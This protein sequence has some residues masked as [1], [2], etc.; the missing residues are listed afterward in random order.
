MAPHE[1]SEERT[2]R[3][4]LTGFT[5]NTGIRVFTFEGI[6][7]DQTRTGFVVEIDLAMT[8]R[9][10]IRLQELPLICRELLERHDEGEQARTFIFTEAEM[11]LHASSCEAEREVRQRTNSMRKAYGKQAGSAWRTPQR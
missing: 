8:R 1:I 4:I 11:I 7:T 10:G 3:Y 9:Y 2:L 5:Q 6:A